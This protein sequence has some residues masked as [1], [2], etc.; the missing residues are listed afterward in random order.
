[1]LY[2]WNFKTKSISKK[3]SLQHN[4]TNAL[5]EKSYDLRIHVFFG[6]K[7]GK[8]PIDTISRDLAVKINVK[9][10]HK[11]IPSECESIIPISQKVTRYCKKQEQQ[12]KKNSAM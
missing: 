11:L 2:N 3:R 8:T 12:P 6:A 5:S 4:C 1:M 9:K 7:S 10:W